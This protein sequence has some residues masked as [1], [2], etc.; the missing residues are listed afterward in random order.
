MERV[1]VV[2]N[3]VFT[4]ESLLPVWE[5]VESGSRLSAEEGLHLFRTPDVAAVG[6][7]A[8]YAKTRV[9]GDNV[10]FVIN[11][12]VNPTNLCA[13]SCKFC[14]FSRKRGDPDAYE[15]SI[16]EI[17]E[18]I[19]DDIREVHIVG[20][21][22]PDWPFEFYESMVRAIHER[23]PQAHIKAFTASEID[24]FERRWKVPPEESLSRLKAVGLSSMPGGG[25]E[26]FSARIQKELFPGKADAKGWLE[27]HGIAH[28]LGIFSNCT[29]LYGHIETLKERVQHLIMLREQQDDSGGFLCFVPLQ[30]QLGKTRLVEKA[31]SPL[32][33]LRTV[34]VSRLML[35]NIPHIKSYWVMLGEEVAG[36]AL[37]FGADDIDGTIGRER[38]AHAAD[39]PSPVGLARERVLRLIHD[40][41]GIPVERDALYNAMN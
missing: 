7:M 11:R 3:L 12:Q 13:N 36:I 29:M 16:E 8:N 9:S 23:L 21:H 28:R 19:D 41:G 5:K 20:G 4:D 38:V 39:A 24:Y 33:S 40:A 17:L 1:R 10:F 18:S 30:Y 32:E 14:D 26:V 25:A 27:I 6:Q 15:M 37:D 2:D 34:A 22:H 35:D 31:I